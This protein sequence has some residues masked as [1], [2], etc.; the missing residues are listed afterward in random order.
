MAY[1]DHE[2]R[3]GAHSIFSMVLVPSALSPLVEQK[4]KSPDALSRFPSF[5]ALQKIET[6][7]FSSKSGS[8]ETEEPVERGQDGGQI[9]DVLVKQY[10]QLYS[11]KSA[12][13]GGRT[14]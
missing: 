4:T 2:T 8:N 3:V 10:G 1:P 11:F 14:V 13:T 9:S 5:R 7:I 12:F 6:G